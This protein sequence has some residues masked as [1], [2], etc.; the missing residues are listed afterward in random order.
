MRVRWQGRQ[1]GRVDGGWMLYRGSYQP[2]ARD[3]VRSDSA[4][5]YQPPY[6]ASHTRLDL[7]KQLIIL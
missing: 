1:A 2:S 4:V 3:Q 5:Q 6:S 7:M